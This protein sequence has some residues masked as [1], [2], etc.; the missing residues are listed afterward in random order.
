MTAA[1]ASGTTTTVTI[2]YAD[3]TAGVDPSTFGIGN[4][5]VSDGATVTGFSASGNVVT[6]TITAPSA[7]W[8]G[9]T[10]GSYT[11]GL[12]AGSVTDL[13][14]NPIAADAAFG[15]FL[16]DTVAPTA[17][18][19]SAPAVT[20]IDG[21]ATT[22]TVTITYAAPPGVDPSTFGT[23]NITVS[24]GATVTGFSASG[25]VV[26]YTITAPE[27]D[28]WATSP[29]GA[30]TIGLV[31]GSVRDAVGNPIAADDSLGSFTVDMTQ[32]TATTT[33]LTE[34]ADNLTFGN[35]VTLSVTIV[36]TAG[37]LVPTGSVSFFDGTTL[38]GTPPLVDGAASFVTSSLTAAAH[39]ITAVYSGDAVFATSTSTPQTLEIAQAG[40]QPGN[41]VSSAPQTF[42]GQD[43]TLTATFSSTA[44]PD[45]A[46]MTGT[47]LF[48]DGSTFLGSTPLV[49]ASLA[50]RL[51]GR[52][53]RPRPT[54]ACR[55]RPWASATTSSRRS[56]PATPTTPARPR[57]RRSRSTSCPPRRGPASARRLAPRG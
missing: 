45:A 22:T 37:D 35:P 53:S 27:P 25:N 44:S 1:D 15:S 24:N 29:Q 40:S 52:P 47:V 57:R 33:H 50:A 5:T 54:P 2:T 13:A 11:I 20:A 43:V 14:G 12:V 31:G 41:L 36:A 39:T 42:Y 51:A 9:S 56:T 49:T 17:T 55:P 6:Y 26:T 10:Q 48:Y 4:I 34:S 7:T 3:A 19:T 32:R 23:G 8:G 18:L 46:P 30:Y 16:V 21:S 38:L 28:T